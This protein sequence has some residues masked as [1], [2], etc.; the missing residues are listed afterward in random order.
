M[1]PDP[2][3]GANHLR[4]LA[5][6][7]FD[8]VSVHLHI[9]WGKEG[10]RMLTNFLGNVALD[11]LLGRAKCAKVLKK[12][13]WIITKMLRFACWKIT[14]QCK[15]Q[16]A[17]STT[18]AA[19]QGRLGAPFSRNKFG[20]CSQWDKNWTNFIWNAQGS[21]CKWGSINPRWRHNSW[22]IACCVFNY[23]KFIFIKQNESFLFVISAAI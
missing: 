13:F 21:Q 7:R 14:G 23:T 15:T 2:A 1:L 6:V 8:T 5:C 4:L 20:H 17:T 3:N 10:L 11:D 16:Q 12:L 9:L 22:M 18:S 19:T